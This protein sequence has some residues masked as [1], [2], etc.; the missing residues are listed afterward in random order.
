MGAVIFGLI[1]LIISLSILALIIMGVYILFKKIFGDSLA[2]KDGKGSNNF[3]EQAKDSLIF[4][5]ILAG[6]LILIS[7]IPLGFVDQLVD[8]RGRL[9]ENVASRMTSEW[10]GHQK[11]SG[12]ILSIP[13][14]YKATVVDKITNPKTG[15]IK[16]VEREVTKE[17]ELI[18]LP[19]DL[20]IETSLETTELSRGIYT[21]PIYDSTHNIN[22]TFKWPDLSILNEKP[23]KF[24]W[25]R[26]MLSF[27][28]TSTRGITGGTQ[29]KWDD[30]VVHL[31]SGTGLNGLEIKGV[32]ARLKLN[33][34]FQTKGADF[35]FALN[36]RGSKGLD[37]APTGRQ[38]EIAL[39]ANW[40]HP[41]FEGSLL[42]STRNIE[43]SAFDASW[44]V[45]H[46]SRSYS[47]VAAFGPV[48]KAS[49]FRSVYNFGFGVNLFQSV[50]L[51]TV[52]DR[53]I[54]YGIMFVALTFFSVFIMEFASGARLHW[55]QHLI[56]G[57]SLSMFYLCVLA[58]SE[59][60]DFGYAYMIGVSVIASMLGIY[61]GFVMGK[62]LY[63]IGISGVM[64][65]LYAVLYSILQME[66]YALLIGTFLLLIFLGLG[67][68]I[69]RKL[70]K[71]V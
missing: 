6:V 50:D 59:H 7:L 57:A 11:I 10:G 56:I 66:D 58:L 43:E 22:G 27:M 69:T 61:T 16:H 39:N 45:T 52:L 20:A 35:N 19:E 25:E 71:E 38:S 23:E 1:G 37:Y 13:Y 28:I 67:M 41:S 24:L 21:V 4:R 62:I 9:Y 34:T 30:Q 70:H 17:K 3:I 31:S 33:P 53:T 46:L 60:I 15:D 51:Y 29:L 14:E 2:A 54:K 32:H 18:L 40:P 55:L 63:G 5:I 8:E 44:N 42:P 64:V 12:P 65:G 68:F 36:L 49:F 47:Q 48:E 26:A